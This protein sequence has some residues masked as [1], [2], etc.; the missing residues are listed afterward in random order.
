[1]ALLGAVT[2]HARGV[3]MGGDAGA[4]LSGAATRWM[5]E[6]RVADPAR[7]AGVYVPQ[8]AGSR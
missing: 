5:V 7:F 8:P 6:Q 2:R 4:A 1:M 3:A